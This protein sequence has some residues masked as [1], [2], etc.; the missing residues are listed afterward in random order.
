MISQDS[1]LIVK[2]EFEQLLDRTW[3]GYLVCVES[4]TSGLQKVGP[5]LFGG[6]LAGSEQFNGT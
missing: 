4:Q 6:K 3:H 2:L 5:V 1:L